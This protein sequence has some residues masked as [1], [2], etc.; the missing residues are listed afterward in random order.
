MLLRNRCV[1]RLFKTNESTLENLILELD[2]ICN[3]VETDFTIFVE[4]IDFDS[5][6]QKYNEKTDGFV[7]Q[8]RC[9]IE[10][11]LSNIFTL[12]LTYAGAILAFDKLNDNTFSSFLFIAM[13]IYTLFSCCFL[14]YEIIDTFSINKNFEKE[15]KAYTNNSPVLLKKVELDKNSIQHR[16][17]CIRIICFVLIFLF[18]SLIIF[19]RCKIFTNVDIAATETP[20]STGSGVK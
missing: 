2:E 3:K 9:I 16:L 11:M 13:S 6:I 7:S 15:L 19:F 12:P 8:A 14:I 1:E 18:I 5:Y 4:K 17:F 10:K 20:L